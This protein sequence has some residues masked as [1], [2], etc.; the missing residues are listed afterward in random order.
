VPCVRLL[1]EALDA[2]FA[3]GSTELLDE[4]TVFLAF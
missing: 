3:T 1:T 2:W 4:E